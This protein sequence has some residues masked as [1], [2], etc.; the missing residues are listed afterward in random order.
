MK[1][2]NIPNRI[3]FTQKKNKNFQWFNENASQNVF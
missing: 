2:Q 1:S 3:E